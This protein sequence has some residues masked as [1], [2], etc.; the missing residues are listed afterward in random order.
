MVVN[1][2]KQK[3]RQHMKLEIQVLEIGT[4]M[5]RGIQVCF[6]LNK[7]KNSPFPIVFR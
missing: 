7:N 3:R 1:I 6:R 5:W 2:I 4:K